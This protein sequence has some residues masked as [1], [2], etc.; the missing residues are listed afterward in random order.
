MMCTAWGRLVTALIGAAALAIAGCNDT[1][2]GSNNSMSSSNASATG[3]WGGSDSVTGLTVTGYIDSAGDAVFIRSDGVQFVGPT[4]LSGDT[5]VAAVVGY[6]D[7]PATFPD[8]SS[9]GLGTLNG[10]VA[11]GSTLTLSLTFTTN[12]GTM[13]PGSWSLSFN[14]LTNNSSSLGTIAATYTDTASGSVITVSANGVVTGQEQNSCVVN[15]NLTIINSTYDIYQVTITY[16]SCTGSYAVLNG[17]ELTGLAVY[18]PNTSPPRL[19]IQLT[20]AS[21][22]GKF[23]LLLNLQGS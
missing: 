2:Y 8:G 4:Q 22:T 16:E 11:T 3:I 14:T 13:L 18:N 12:G 7:F 19:T 21:A 10:T 23:A 6:T 1:G 20:G 5:L 15:G 17:V 9:Y